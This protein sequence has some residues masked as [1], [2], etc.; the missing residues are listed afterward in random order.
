MR[1]FAK[2]GPL[3]AFPFILEIHEYVVE[4]EMQFMV[5]DFISDWLPRFTE[6]TRK[7]TSTSGTYICTNGSSTATWRLEKMSQLPT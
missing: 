1:L 4:N 6:K 5:E 3:P 7:S 2:V